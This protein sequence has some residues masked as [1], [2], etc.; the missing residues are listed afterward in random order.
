MGEA[1]RRADPLEPEPAAR[2]DA[3]LRRVRR[4]GRLRRRPQGLRRARRRS[5]SA[6]R[7]STTTRCR[8]S[9]RSGMLINVVAS[10]DLLDADE[11]WAKKVLA[12]CDART[13]PYFFSPT[14]VSKQSL[15]KEEQMKEDPQS[16]TLWTFVVTS[17]ALVMVT[18]DNLVVTTAL[19]VIRKDL[20]R[21]DRGARVDGERLH[22]HLRRAPPDGRRARRPL[23]PAAHVRDRARRSSR[24][25]RRPPR[26]RPSIERARRRPR[27]S[28]ASAAR[29]SR[30]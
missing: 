7:A 20:R 8:S 12:F 27:R 26:S 10:M 9:S 19:P 6:R 16:R 22:A 14:E 21:G 2:A 11:A 13:E 23:R 3:D 30:R 25:P 24:S 17:L 5:S 18:L 29:S 15:A 28:R 4:P 1:V